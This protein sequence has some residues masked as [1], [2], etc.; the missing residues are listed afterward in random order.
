MKGTVI[1]SAE[2]RYRRERLPM[3]D[4]NEVPKQL[5]P[6]PDFEDAEIVNRAWLAT[7]LRERMIL[8]FW[9][10]NKARPEFICRKYSIA[11]RPASVLQIQIAK[12]ERLVELRL[13]KLSTMHDNVCT[14]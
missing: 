2:G 6:E 4:P 8:K 1:G 5:R 14:T 13:V 7:P 3:D 9:Y 11:H 10:V 12:A